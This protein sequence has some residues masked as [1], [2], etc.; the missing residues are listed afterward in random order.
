MRGKRVIRWILIQFLVAVILFSGYAVYKLIVIKPPSEE[1]NEAREAIAL[2]KE[3]HATKY[4]SAKL[5]KAEQLF[6]ETM[7]EWETQNQKFFIFRDFSRTVELAATSLKYSQQAQNSAGTAKNN[8][9]AKLENELKE[10]ADNISRFDRLYKK[11]PLGRSTFDKYNDGKL[12]YLEAESNCKKGDYQ[13]GLIL[14][15]LAKEKME[16]TEAA[17]HVKLNRFFE[18]Y[19][20]WKRNAERAVQLS[21]KGQTVVLIN[22]MESTVS[23][24]KSGK[25]VKVLEAEFG[26][27]WMGDK[28]MKGDKTTP[29][30]IYKV[31]EKK[32]GV[33][34]KYH[35][36]LLLNYPNDQDLVKFEKL[37]R[38][39]EISKNAQIGGLIEIHGGGGKGVH[40]T[41]GCIALDN[42]DMDA[43]YDLCSASTPV[44][45]VGSEITLEE[46]LKQ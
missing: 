40:W 3:V 29:E 37:K 45:I 22:K 5:L 39:G 41:D 20:E 26:L 14:A 18:S 8:S 21:K 1:V 25:K 36:A 11:L 35:K 23:V 15:G 7:A 13:K 30:G 38:S 44:V 33:R 43:V 9:K 10:I 27:N 4:A 24:L 32:R 12:K 28:I 2:A 46:Y 17:S 42:K 31:V 6:K 19:P 34:T 16:Q